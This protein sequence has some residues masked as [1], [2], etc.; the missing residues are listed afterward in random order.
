VF[1][2]VSNELGELE[3]GLVA[4]WLGAIGAVLAGGAAA[5]VVA[6]AVAWLAPELRELPPLP[7]LE[8]E[9]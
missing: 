8:P 5:I 7:T 4:A 6:C 1:I 2:G 9:A 3:S